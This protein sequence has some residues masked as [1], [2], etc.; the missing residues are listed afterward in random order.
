MLIGCVFSQS[1]TVSVISANM[2]RGLRWSTSCLKKCRLASLALDV[3]RRLVLRIA[4]SARQEHKTATN[5]QFL[6]VTLRLL[7]LW[8]CVRASI[9]LWLPN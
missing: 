9:A 2:T 3:F 8:R 4:T 7:C 5:L 1:I 6:A